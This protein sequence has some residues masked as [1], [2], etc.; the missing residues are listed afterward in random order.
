MLNSESD[1]SISHGQRVKIY[2]IPVLVII[3]DTE[4]IVCTAMTEPGL[5]QTVLVKKGL[6]TLDVEWVKRYYLW[7]LKNYS[8]AN[9]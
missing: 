5:E 8:N 3:Q 4:P 2:S 7:I 9:V 1:L 6:L